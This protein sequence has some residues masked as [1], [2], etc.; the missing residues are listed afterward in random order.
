MI[1]AVILAAGACFATRED[2]RLLQTQLQQYQA[3]SAQSDSVRKAQLDRVIEQL[4]L[5]GDSLGDL[6]TRLT[7]FQGDVEGSVYSMGQQLIQ[8]QELTGQSQRRLQELRAGLEVQR[9]TFTQQPAQGTPGQPVGT[10]PSVASGVDSGRTVVATTPPATTA[11]ATPGGG[12]GTPGPNELYQL[13]LD[14][15]R[16]GST[17]AARSA[18]TDLL[19]QYPNA[20]VASDAQFYVADSYDREGNTAAADSVYQLVVQRYPS[21]ERAPTAL[22]KHGLTLVTAG[23]VQAARAALQQVVSKY[24]RSDEAVLAKDRLRTLK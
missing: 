12:A 20:D 7:K 13:A 3:Q 19:K 14:Q 23:K 1:P 22:Y 16:R 15:L 10:T 9:G 17:G 8:I 21:S 6:G 11:A 18:L 4:G 5:V 24:P 2:V